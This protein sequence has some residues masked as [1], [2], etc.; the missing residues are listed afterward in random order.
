[1][2]RVLRALSSVLFVPA[3]WLRVM[4]V[5]QV[6]AVRIGALSRRLH[7]CSDV[8]PTGK[9]LYGNIRR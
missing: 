8:Q 3:R 1:M 9:R 5:T 6:L 2:L 7:H 4:T